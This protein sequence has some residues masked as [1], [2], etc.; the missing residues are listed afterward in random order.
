MA[1]GTPTKV[2]G[3]FTEL[4][5]S[6]KRR[7]EKERI[8]SMISNQRCTCRLCDEHGQ[9]GKPENPMW[10]KRPGEPG[11]VYLCQGPDEATLSTDGRPWA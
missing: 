5:S 8:S 10:S 6:R 7:R 3:P 4:G 1:H 9:R 2:H 11:E